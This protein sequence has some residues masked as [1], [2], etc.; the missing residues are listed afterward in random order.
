MTEQWLK[1]L[2]VHTRIEQ[3]SGTGMTKTMQRV[4]LMGQAGFI[5]VLIKYVAG[6]YIRKGPA[7][8]ALEKVFYLRVFQLQPSVQSATS[9]I[10]EVDDSSHTILLSF[11]DL[12]AFVSKVQVP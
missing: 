1:A 12:N 9:I 6:R 7:A 4:A 3:L 8:I 2:Q 11:K 5:Q 10:A